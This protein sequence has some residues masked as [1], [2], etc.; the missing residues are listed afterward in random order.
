M[1]LRLIYCKLLFVVSGKHL[2]SSIVVVCVLRGTAAA[3]WV[4]K[5]W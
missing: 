5:H 3:A 1:Y 4:V 2:M